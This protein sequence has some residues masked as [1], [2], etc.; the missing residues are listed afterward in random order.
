MM[1]YQ[2]E[3]GEVVSRKL[4]AFVV[5]DGECHAV[6]EWRNELSTVPISELWTTK[7]TALAELK[8]QQHDREIEGEA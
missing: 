5:I 7:A 4:H 8:R 2:V 3:Y 6:L 1:L